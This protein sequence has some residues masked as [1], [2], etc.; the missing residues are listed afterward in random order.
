MYIIEA[1][2]ANSETMTPSELLSEI[3]ALGLSTPFESCGMVR[4]DRDDH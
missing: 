4:D 1:A 2:V 3:Q